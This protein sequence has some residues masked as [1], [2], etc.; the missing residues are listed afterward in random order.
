M[1]SMMA[2]VPQD[3]ILFSGSLRQNIFPPDKTMGQGEMDE[4]IDAANLRSLI[5]RLP[6]GL[7]TDLIKSGASLSS[8]ERQLVAIARALAR[9]PELILLDEATS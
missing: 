8:G 9:D 6:G 1:R 2:L 5:Q 7:E 4:I 3:S